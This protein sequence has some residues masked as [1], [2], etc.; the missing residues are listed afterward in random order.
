MLF[1]YCE[2]CNIIAE[3]KDDMENISDNCDITSAF[4]DNMSNII[5]D[6]NEHNEGTIFKKLFISIKDTSFR[7][8]IV[9]LIFFTIL[10]FSCRLYSYV[11]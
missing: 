6:A 11:H 1:L 2:I 5:I 3:V 10:L 8:F 7:L 4:Q 9:P